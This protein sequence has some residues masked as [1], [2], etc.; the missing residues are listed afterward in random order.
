VYLVIPAC[1]PIFVVRACRCVCQHC[2][3]VAWYVSVCI[4]AVLSPWDALCSDG[5]LCTLRSPLSVCAFHYPTVSSIYHYTPTA[6]PTLPPAPCVV[7]TATDASGVPDGWMGLDIGS[8]SVVNISKVRTHN[9]VQ[10]QCR[11]APKS[12]SVQ[13]D[14]SSLRVHARTCRHD[15]FW[16]S[17]TSRRICPCRPLL[18]GTDDTGV[19]LGLGQWEWVVYVVLLDWHESQS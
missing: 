17:S 2:R 4:C 16:H 1:Q 19:G 9:I 6:S 8:Q 7:Q 14:S 15:H 5:I 10:L 18:C 12:C 3:L 11:V 13:Q